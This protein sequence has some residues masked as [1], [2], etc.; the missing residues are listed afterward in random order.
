MDMCG[1]T[2][3]CSRVLSRG[4]ETTSMAEA[5]A[6]RLFSRCQRLHERF[7]LPLSFSSFCASSLSSRNAARSQRRDSE[8]S[9]RLHAFR[10]PCA[11]FSSAARA[12]SVLENASLRAA[13]KNGTPAPPLCTLQKETSQTRKTRETVAV[14][15]A[16]EIKKKSNSNY[17]L[18]VPLSSPEGQTNVNS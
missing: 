16:Y 5:H 4:A 14:L 17:H 10:V 12:R 1:T 9:L 6:R 18:L 2:V 13:S 3:L 11:I 15:F 7:P 8:A